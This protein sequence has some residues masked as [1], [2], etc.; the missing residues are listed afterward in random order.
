MFEAA[1]LLSKERKLRTAGVAAA[2]QSGG[3]CTLFAE[4]AGTAGLRAAGVLADDSAPA[5]EGA[6]ALRLA[7]QPARRDGTGRGRD[8]DVR[9][10]RSRRSR[11]I[12]SVGVIAFDAFPPRLEGETPWADPVLRE[13]ARRC[14]ATT[15]VVFASVAM[16]PLAYTPAAKSFTYGSMRCRSCR[17]TTPRR[18]RSG[19]SSSSRA[20]TG[21][22]DR[23]RPAAAP[24]PGEGACGCCAATSGPI[25]EATGARLLELYGVRRPEGADGRARRSAAAAFAPR[26]SGS[27]S[28]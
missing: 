11:T 5:G 22:R 24:Q 26:G 21:A 12:P 28:S 20:S 14:G 3:A 2:L 4:A 8:R 1:L 25:D 18:A 27:R 16:S 10:T 6:A 17:A 19:R 13:G 15:G 23:R 9:G 7:E